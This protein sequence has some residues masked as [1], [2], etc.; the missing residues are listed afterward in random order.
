MLRCMASSASENI[1]LSASNV[2]CLLVLSV[3]IKDADV[4]TEALDIGTN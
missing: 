3:T 2:F 1:S 4:L